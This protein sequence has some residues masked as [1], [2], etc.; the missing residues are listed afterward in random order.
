M[1]LMVASMAGCELGCIVLSHLR[2]QLSTLSWQHLLITS[3]AVMPLLWCM[4]A[5]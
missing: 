1:L 5:C 2:L 4:P 3:D